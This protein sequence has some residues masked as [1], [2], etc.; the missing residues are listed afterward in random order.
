MTKKTFIRAWY[1][2]IPRLLELFNIDQLPL[3][4]QTALLSPDSASSKIVLANI[5]GAEL[6]NYLR[7]NQIHHLYRIVAENRLTTERKGV[8]RKGVRSHFDLSFLFFL[9]TKRYNAWNS[10]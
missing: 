7:E 5:M 4:I 8:K 2:S 3:N 9:L 6:L 10:E 1:A